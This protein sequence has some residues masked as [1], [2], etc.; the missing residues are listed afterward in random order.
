MGARDRRQVA[1]PIPTLTLTL[2][3]RHPRGSP[4]SPIRLRIID[5]YP[6]VLYGLVALVDDSSLAASATRRMGELI[7]GTL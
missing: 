4:E 5:L 6:Y 3:D 7:V 1:R 2:R